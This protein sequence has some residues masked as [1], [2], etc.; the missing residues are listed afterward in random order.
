MLAYGREV[1]AA[2]LWTPVLSLWPVVVAVVVMVLGLV[3]RWVIRR[4]HVAPAA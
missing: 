1:F 3:A 2:A 4:R